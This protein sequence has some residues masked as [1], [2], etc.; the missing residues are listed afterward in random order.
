[1]CTIEMMRKNANEENWE[2]FF[3]VSRQILKHREQ[4]LNKIVVLFFV[5]PLHMRKK[6]IWSNN[7]WTK[8]AIS[9]L[10][11]HG[12]PSNKPTPTASSSPTFRERLFTFIFTTSLTSR[13]SKLTS[14]LF[15]SSQLKFLLGSWSILRMW[16]SR[17]TSQ[18]LSAAKPRELLGRRST[19]SKT[20]SE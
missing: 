8:L 4:L 10:T 9:C 6:A 20:D 7:F 11:F 15:S 5:L 2:T 12:S 14:H 19:G 18:R 3:Y 1:M 16:P 13:Q 17:R